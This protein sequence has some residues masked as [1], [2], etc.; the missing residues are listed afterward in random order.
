ML[1]RGKLAALSV[2]GVGAMLGLFVMSLSMGVVLGL[3]GYSFDLQADTISGSDLVMYGGMYQGPDQSG[4][5]PVI[6]AEMSSADISGMTITRTMDVA[7]LTVVA[8]I[9]GDGASVDALCMKAAGMDIGS[10]TLNDMRMEGR[11]PTADHA[12]L[13]IT[14]G[15]VE[16][17]NLDADVY[18]ITAASMGV[19]N[20][21]VSIEVLA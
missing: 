5:E 8:T 16:M 18:L 1:H 2:A 13:E 19:T 4:M 11:S 14:A 12:G 21:S 9:T 20:M 6:V 17:S 7:G 15:T 3:P 10:V